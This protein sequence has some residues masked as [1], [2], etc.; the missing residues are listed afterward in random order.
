MNCEKDFG[1]KDLRYSI[2]FVAEK[3]KNYL[4]SSNENST[5]N[6]NA[7]FMIIMN[8]FLSVWQN[9]V[10]LLEH[11]YQVRRFDEIFLYPVGP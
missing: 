8:V 9:A 1:I 5:R 2:I 10:S 4:Y 7:H 11:K 3:Y 6:G